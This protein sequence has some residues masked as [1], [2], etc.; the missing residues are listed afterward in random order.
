V[1]AR[2]TVLITGA[3]AGIG[4]AFAEVFA[5]N[6][7]DIVAVARR[8]DRLRQLAASLSTDHGIRVHA[9]T[10]DL[11]RVDAVDRLCR[12]LDDMGVQVDALVNNA[13]FGVAGAF[14]NTEWPRHAE[15]LQ[16]MLIDV[17]ELSHRLLPGMVERGYG[18]II[19]VASLAGLLPGVAGHTLYAAT[20]MF[21]I[22]FSESL[23]SE[24]A[25]RGVHVSAVC[26]GF[27]WSEFHDVSGTREIVNHMP[28]FMWMDAARVAREGYEAV[29]AGRAVYVPGRVNK[30]IATLGRLLPPRVVWRMNRRA[31]SRYRRAE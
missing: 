14:L 11:A 23:A 2:R 9:L 29:M 20:K 12:R 24:V 15:F 28:G 7:F 21:L 3:S 26:P 27:T 19:N 1:T 10:G 17:V 22:R 6:G 8:E 13:G 4:R 16:L 30:T 25:P 18:R 31:A 5:A